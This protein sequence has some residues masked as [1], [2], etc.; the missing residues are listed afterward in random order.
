MTPGALRLAVSTAERLE[1]IVR[2]R[3]V[4]APGRRR[5]TKRAHLYTRSGN[6]RAFHRL[7]RAHGL[8][9]PQANIGL[10]IWEA[11]F[12]WPE[13]GLVIEIDAWHTH[14]NRRYFETDRDKDEFLDDIGLKVRRVTDVRL[15]ENPTRVAATVGRALGA[16]TFVPDRAATAWTLRAGGDRG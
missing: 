8:P 3:L 14:G 4:T 15:R 10:G 1:L 7:L 9:L 11:D 13:H 5:V 16:C 12:L 2:D 6:E